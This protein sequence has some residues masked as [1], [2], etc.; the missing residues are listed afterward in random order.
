MGVRVLD[1]LQPAGVFTY[2]EIISGIPRGS[3]NEKQISDYLIGFAKNKNFYAHQDKTLNVIIKKPGTAGYEDSPPVMLQ[4]HVD[5]VCEKNAGTSHDFK[6]DPL[7]LYIE[8]DFIKARGTTLG[9]DDG[10]A[11]AYI[12]ALLDSDDIP[13]P[14]IEAV[15]TT[16]EEV[17]LEGAA[18]VETKRLSAKRMINLDCGGEGFFTVSCAG[19]VKIS[20]TFDEEKMNIQDAFA[21]RPEQKNYN[22]DDFNFI[23]IDIKGLSGGHSGADIHHGKANANVLAGRLLYALIKKFDIRLA[24]IGGG[25]KDNAIP[26]ESCIVVAVKSDET[27]NLTDEIKRF[28]QTF[29]NEYRIADPGLTVTTGRVTNINSTWSKEFTKKIASAILTAPNGVLAMDADIPGLVETSNNFGAIRSKVDEI[30]FSNAVRSSVSSRKRFVVDK[31]TAAAE[32]LGAETACESDYPAW[33]YQKDSELRKLFTEVYVDLY[34]KEPVADGIHAGLECGVF[35][36]K[37]PGLD[38]IACGPDMHGI[39]TPDE[40]LSIS[41]TARV[42]DFLVEV[43]RRLK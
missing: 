27:E 34:G 7:K 38:M 41:S 23:R 30:V 19:G 40:R 8:G 4:G 22:I 37:I 10:I 25:M 36:G 32:S 14:P 43:L 3:G 24:D 15:F 35:G 33:A 39:H 42:W 6:N 13:H 29:K 16:N 1:N 28:D 12:L 11:V 17:G 26:R 21:E 18:V 31:I 2:F 20:V 5:M 9:A